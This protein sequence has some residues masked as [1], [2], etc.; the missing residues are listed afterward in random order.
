MTDDILRDGDRLDARVVRNR[1]LQYSQLKG[2]PY[3][4]LEFETS[5]SR[6]IIPCRRWLSDGAIENAIRTFQACGWKGENVDELATGDLCGMDRNEVSVTVRVQ[7]YQGK[8]QPPEVGF[9]NP[10]TSHVEMTPNELKRFGEK[11]RGL[12][13]R[14]QKEMPDDELP[15]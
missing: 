2:T 1:G 10:I 13:R 3:I 8:E 12:V 5:K 6:R 9:V 11:H 4:L 15:F 7:E 14:L